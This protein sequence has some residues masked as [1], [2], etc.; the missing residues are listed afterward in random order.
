MSATATFVDKTLHS[1]LIA[2]V[3]TLL[4]I[5]GADETD[6]VIP[7]S[8]SI[9]RELPLDHLALFIML[10]HRGLKLFRFS[11]HD[12]LVDRAVLENDFSNVIKLV[13][14]GEDYVTELI[15][16]GR[17]ENLAADLQKAVVVI[18]AI[19][20][21]LRNRNRKTSILPLPGQVSMFDVCLE[22]SLRVRD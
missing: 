21:A 8:V 13:K 12:D 20:D 15:S 19:K 11:Q 9:L 6:E 17:P 5:P 1:M 22:R 2:T 14:L 16:K 7:M 3:E 18:S 10:T 4:S